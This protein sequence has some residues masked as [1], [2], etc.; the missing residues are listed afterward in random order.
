VTANHYNR[1]ARRS[2][3]CIKARRRRHSARE[4]TWRGRVAL[5]AHGGDLAR[6]AARIAEELEL[7]PEIRKLLSPACIPTGESLRAHRLRAWASV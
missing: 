3:L 7:S 5:T 1:Q 6:V 4:A 2:G